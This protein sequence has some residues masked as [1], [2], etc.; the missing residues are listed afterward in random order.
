M[1]GGLG[2]PSDQWPIPDDGRL[3]SLLL[4]KYPRGQHRHRPPGRAFCLALL[5]RDTR[6]VEMR[7]VELLGEPRQEARRGD[8]APGATCD[9]CEIGEVAVEPLLIIVPERQL[10]A[11]V[12]CI[13]ARADQRPRER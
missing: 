5:P 12:V 4:R 8:A 3:L 13:V 11:A 7:P 1:R 9:V 6:N 2:K 10:P